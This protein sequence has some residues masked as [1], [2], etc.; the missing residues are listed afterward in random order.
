ML[1]PLGISVLGPY[2]IPW[3]C[4]FFKWYV[5]LVHNEWIYNLGM[6]KTCDRH[7][8]PAQL[9]LRWRRAHRRSWHSGRRRC[10]PRRRT[11]RRLDPV[12]EGSDPAA[13]GA[14]AGG[15]NNWRR[16]SGASYA[17]PT[18]GCPK[19]NGDRYGWSDDSDQEGVGRGRQRMLEWNVDRVRGVG[20]RGR[21]PH[22]AEMEGEGDLHFRRSQ[23]D[24]GAWETSRTIEF[25]MWRHSDNASAS[26]NLVVGTGEYWTAANEDDVEAADLRE[27]TAS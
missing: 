23:G 2:G 19:T 11:T 20:A 9:R 14:G 24:S 10:C 15:S 16:S 26:G 3:S 18:R 17:V 7:R 22:Q 6:G 13:T 12:A 5:W 21:W 4:N 25:F 27:W 1:K 8:R